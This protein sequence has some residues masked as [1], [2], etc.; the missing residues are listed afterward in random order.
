MGFVKAFVGSW[1]FTRNY[2]ALLLGLPTLVFLSVSAA[3]A[4][5]LAKEP[6]DD[7]AATYESAAVR[8]GQLGEEDKADLMWERLMQMRP[9]EHRY[10]HTL[11]M[12]LMERGK[13]AEAQTY[14]DVLTGEEGYTPTRMWLVYEAQKSD[15][16]IQLTPEQQIEQL[17]AAIKEEPLNAT[18]HRMLANAYVKQRDFRLA[19]RHLERA[20]K[21]HP[22]LGLSLFE[23]KTQLNREDKAELKGMLRRASIALEDNVVQNPGDAQMRVYWAQS[24]LYLGETEEAE[25]ILNEALAS[26]DDPI[27]RKALTRLLTAQARQLVQQSGVNVQKA[28]RYLVRAV[29]INPDSRDLGPLCVALAARGGQFTAE[30]LAPLI[31]GIKARV[32]EDSENSAE[33]LLLAQLL[34]LTKQYE[35]AIDILERFGQQNTDMQSML[36]RAYR[37]NGQQE[38]AEALA[39]KLITTIAEQSE[40][41]PQDASTLVSLIDVLLIGRHYG[42]VV[43]E[44]DRFAERSEK[45]LRDLDMIIRARYVAACVIMYGT[46]ESDGEPNAIAWLEKAVDSGQLSA[47]LL[48]LLAT[49][50]LGENSSA[51]TAESLI[52]KALA[53][54]TANPQIYTAVGT[55]ALTMGENET[56]V[57]HLRQALAQMPQNP[58]L[59]NNLALAL[60]RSSSDNFTEA[61]Q[62]C[63][64][65]L[66]QLPDHPDVLTTRAEVLIARKH[67][68]AARVD[69][70]TALP[71]RSEQPLVRRMLIAVYEALNLP[72]LAKEHEEALV[73]ME[74][75][76]P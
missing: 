4:W 73:T 56:A 54:G 27:L 16:A 13:Y 55:Q 63:E 23:V 72:D 43:T 39:E 2:R 70:E 68:A 21:N 38:Q 20:V 31:V 49:L 60:I 1:F 64:S 11:T 46:D 26:S 50:S 76:Q 17:Q 24:L 6:S 33:Q 12:S 29:Q 57:H 37:E 65:S 41:K 51:A 8:A 52:N 9:D 32:D 34:T 40:S 3:T 66:Q 53:Q 30:E 44:V 35:P 22:E 7:L 58:V 14:L 42:Q 59:Q 45:T 48:Q 71:R 62:L 67:W 15:A 36:V 28:T 10:R 5:Q 47:E 19:E 61:R 18:A 69:L 25:G 74:A 75:R